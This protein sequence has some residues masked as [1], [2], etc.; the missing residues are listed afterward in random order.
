MNYRKV[1][2][3]Q[4]STLNKEIL[5]KD[6]RIY[7]RWRALHI[8]IKLSILDVYRVWLRW[9]ALLIVT[10]L[11]ILDACKTLAKTLNRKG[12]QGKI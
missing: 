12:I 6:P 8:V 9:R 11:S 5:K 2:Y 7:L 4:H 1:S 3:R 10:K